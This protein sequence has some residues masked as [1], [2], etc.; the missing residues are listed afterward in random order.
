ML[1][2]PP[3][4]RSCLSLPQ[5]P[6]YLLVLPWSL[7]AVGGVNVVVRNLYAEFSRGTAWQPRLLVADWDQPRPVSR[8]DGQEW[9]LRL[10]NLPSAR[11]IREIAGVM[12]RLP[13]ALYRL[14]RLLQEWRV[15]VANL[16]YPTGAILSFALLRRF[17][18]PRFALVASFHGMDLE[19]LAAAGGWRR[20]LWRWA[21][22]QS[23]RLVCV[24]EVQAQRLRA[25]LPHCAAQVDVIHNGIDGDSL[26]VPAAGHPPRPYVIAVATYEEKKGLDVL[27]R[28]FA[29]IAA[30]YPQ[31]DLHVAG[32]REAAYEPL[33]ALVTRLGLDDRVILHQDVPHDEVLRLMAGATLMVLPSRQEPFG[34]V[35]LEAGLLRTP[36]VA[37]RVGGIPEVVLDGTTGRLVAP[38]DVAALAAA[39]VI[40]L[41][42]PARARQQAEAMRERVRHAFSWRRACERYGEIARN[43]S[44]Q[45]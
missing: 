17:G 25:L 16:H 3:R 24:S 26:P 35:L 4:I 21:V 10:P 40:T 36:I 43:Q 5:R 29:G 14:G 12:T 13:V 44:T 7:D 6:T 33:A 20:V 11:G 2:M 27:V 18:R 38:D 23:D 19:A 8:R 39:I 32:R 42:D 37:T 1:V 22:S 28:A 30:R 31:L 15:E 45:R 41:E 34:I 9:R